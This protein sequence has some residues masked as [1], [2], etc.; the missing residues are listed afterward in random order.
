MGA[1]AELGRTGPGTSRWLGV[2]QVPKSYWT[3][4]TTNATRRGHAVEVSLDYVADLFEQQDGACALSGLSIGFEGYDKHTA[5][6]DRIDSKLGYIV[7]NVQW[8]HKDVNRLKWAFTEQRFFELC[9]LVTSHQKQT[10]R[11]R[12]ITQITRSN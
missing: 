10:A 2:G 11:Q 7:G 1:R 6:L 8:V 9:R 3:R 5:S 12:K 4:V